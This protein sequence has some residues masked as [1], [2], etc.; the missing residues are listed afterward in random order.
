ML[1]RWQPLS[2]KGDGSASKRIRVNMP[3]LQWGPSYLFDICCIWLSAIRANHVGAKC[4]SDLESWM[5]KDKVPMS[6][7]S[8]CSGTDSPHWAFGAMS[9]ALAH[10]S[11]GVNFTHECSAEKVKCKQDFIV[12]MTKPK[13]LVSDIFHLTSL[14]ACDTITSQ[15]FLP[16]LELSKV[17]FFLAGF[18]CK[19]VSS[20]NANKEGACQAVWDFSTSTG[21]TFWGVLLVL[22]RIRPAA[23]LLENVMGLLKN[24]QHRHV[25]RTLDK[26]GYVA[27]MFLMDGRCFGHPQVRPRIYFLGIRK[28]LVLV[29]KVSFEYLQALLTSLMSMAKG[30]QT[31]GA[32]IDTFLLPEDC[33]YINDLKVKASRAYEKKACASPPFKKQR[34]AVVPAWVARRAL[35]RS[36]KCRSNWSPELDQTFPGFAALPDRCKALLEDEGVQF[37][38]VRARF[39]NVS[40]SEVTTSIGHVTTITPKSIIWVEHRGRVLS[41]REALSLQGIHIEQEQYEQLANVVSEGQLYHAAKQIST[42]GRGGYSQCN[43]P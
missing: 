2:S 20:L 34:A 27:E 43:R 41:A 24:D 28:D 15:K 4:L 12:H 10:I 29:A 35:V 11:V 32:D 26:A 37:P 14:E 42:L 8:G 33:E 36:Q 5:H 40:Q 16:L 7:A 9:Q 13:R 30:A 6:W 38:S 21:S 25:L 31:S 1:E 22:E 17:S 3:T 18:V 23:V 19:A 39:H